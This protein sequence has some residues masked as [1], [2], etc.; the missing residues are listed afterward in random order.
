MATMRARIEL[1]GASTHTG[2]GRSCERGKPFYSTNPAEIAYYRTCGDFNV[3]ILSSDDDARKA[4][5]AKKV[6]TPPPPEDDEP[7]GDDPEDDEEDPEDGEAT[8]SYTKSALMGQNKDSLSTIAFDDFGL[9]LDG[10]KLTKAKMVAAIMKAQI[11]ALQSAD[12]A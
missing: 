6:T 12:E 9:E 5:R 3:T 11:E 10:E 2:G 1:S 7:E 8:A 4:K